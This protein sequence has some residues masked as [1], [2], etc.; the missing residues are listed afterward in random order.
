MVK[1]PRLLAS[2]VP[3][4]PPVARR[5]GVSGVVIVEATVDATGKVTGAKVLSGPAMLHQAA[6]DAVLK[7]KYEP[8]TLNGQ[9][10]ETPVRVSFNFKP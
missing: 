8:G 5:N 3:N 2:S 7:F 6:I 4:Y 10:T 1:A 9:P